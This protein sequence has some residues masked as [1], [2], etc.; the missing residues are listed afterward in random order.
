[1]QNLSKRLWGPS[2]NIKQVSDII[3][4]WCIKAREKN[5]LRK[6]PPAIFYAYVLED[7]PPLYYFA[8][9]SSVFKYSQK[10]LPYVDQTRDT[11]LRCLAVALKAHFFMFAS[12]T[13]CFEPYFF[14]IPNLKDPSRTTMGLIY[15]IEKEDKCIVV[16]EEDLEQIYPVG[17]NKVLYR[18]PAVVGEDSFKWFHMKNWYK[19]K[20]AAQTENAN[21]PWSDTTWAQKCKEAESA[22]ELSKYATV[23]DIPFEIK[24]AIKPLG[25]EWAN[26]A[27]KWYLPKGFDVESVNEYVDYQKKLWQAKNPAVAQGNGVT[28][29][30]HQPNNGLRQ[31]NGTTQARAPF[32]RD[33]NKK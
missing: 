9:I 11:L 2:L 4:G 13:V 1:M 22:E 23:L 12:D 20:L 25:I 17:D 18:F 32:V 10:D 7:T 21:K 15:K 6:K 28:Q 30:S 16:C 8:N 27:K 24:D 29:P 31:N 14:V 19:V 3:I 26:K 5:I 33:D